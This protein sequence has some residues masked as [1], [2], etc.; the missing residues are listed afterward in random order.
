MRKLW[1]LFQFCCSSVNGK[2]K[3]GGGGV[4]DWKSRGKKG[5]RRIEKRNKPQTF[6]VFQLKTVLKIFPLKVWGKKKGLLRGGGFEVKKWSWKV[7]VQLDQIVCSSG[8]DAGVCLCNCCAAFIQVML[9]LSRGANI[10]KYFLLPQHSS[11]RQ[12]LKATPVIKEDFSR[13][14]EKREG[15]RNNYHS[16][17]CRSKKEQH[18]Q[19][20]SSPPGKE[21]HSSPRVPSV[22]ICCCA[23]CCVIT[24]LWQVRCLPACLT[25][26]WLQMVQPKILHTPDVAEPW[27]LL[28]R[29]IKVHLR[30]HSKKYLSIANRKMLL[31]PSR[32]P[33]FSIPSIL[34][35]KREARGGPGLS[36]AC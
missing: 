22:S 3:K 24:L 8:D 1:L 17:S 25:T 12:G 26:C 21:D 4:K 18:S 27:C 33:N 7:F 14:K 31:F 28:P 29:W 13:L 20:A 30:R 10:L 23:L 5:R 16:E 19:C 2:I 32:L 36:A 6:G 9:H 34:Q 11:V 15:K 35:E